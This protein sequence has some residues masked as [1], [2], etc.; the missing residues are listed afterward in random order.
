MTV[1]VLVDQLPDERIKWYF[2]PCHKIKI[3][4]H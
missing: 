4:A 2:M 3:L 1:A